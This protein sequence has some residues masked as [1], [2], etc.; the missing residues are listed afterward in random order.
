MD[1]GG[2]GQSVL[3]LRSFIGGAKWVALEVVWWAAFE[4]KVVSRTWVHNGG[5]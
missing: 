1:L 5:D 3:V 4:G 2:G